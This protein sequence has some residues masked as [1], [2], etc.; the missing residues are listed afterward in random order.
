MA[1][2]HCVQ[3]SKKWSSLPLNMPNLL[4]T[5]IRPFLSH[6]IPAPA[7]LLPVHM[8]SSSEELCGLLN[9]IYTIAP[10]LTHIWIC[11]LGP[12]DTMRRRPS[13][14]VRTAGSW[15]LPQGC[16]LSPGG[17][18]SSE[19][20]ESPSWHRH[21]CCSYPDPAGHCLPEDGQKHLQS[22]LSSPLSTS[23]RG[24]DCSHSQRHPLAGTP[25]SSLPHYTIPTSSHHH[26]W[27]SRTCRNQ[28]AL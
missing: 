2:V 15:K 26:F 1:N 16:T 7:N 17:A 5:A 11:K 25:P 18:R 4:G 20:S 27:R 8:W 6:H 19:Q 21:L 3:S 10:T 23:S 22:Q 12:E 14:R 28:P 24:T 13:L 9:P